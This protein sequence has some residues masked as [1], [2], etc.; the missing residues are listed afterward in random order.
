VAGLSR[1][2]H[3][4]AIRGWQGGWCLCVRI[5]VRAYCFRAGGVGGAKSVYAR[6]MHLVAC[7]VVSFWCVRHA[8]PPSAS[9][10][11]LGMTRT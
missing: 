11:V 3:V 6:G 7:L 2:S 10:L 9:G 4:S 5:C 1:R 8:R